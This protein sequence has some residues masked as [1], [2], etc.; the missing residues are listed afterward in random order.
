MLLETR[1]LVDHT[2]ITETSDIAVGDTLDKIGRDL[3]P[4]EILATTTDGM[5]ARALESFCF[6]PY[7]EES[8][9]PSVEVTVQLHVPPQTRGAR[10]C[11]YIQPLRVDPVCAL[12]H[13]WRM[14]EKL[15]AKNSASLVWG[16]KFARFAISRD[17]AYE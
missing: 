17:Q 12:L 15:G 1:S 11:S 8:D 2:I 16:A 9:A 3:L 7:N 14:L 4:S 13:W 6:P 5:Y 10:V